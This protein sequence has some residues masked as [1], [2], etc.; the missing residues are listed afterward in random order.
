MH[1]DV[2]SISDHATHHSSRIKSA[3]EALLGRAGQ[4]SFVIFKER[5]SEKFVQ[6]AGSAQEPLLFD[7]PSI[8]LNTGEME[9]A[10]A[11]FAKLGVSPGPLHNEHVTFQL[12]LNRNVDRASEITLSVFRD[13]YCFPPSFELDVIEN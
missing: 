8:P 11:F 7:L 12:K 5:K 4:D 13:V 9:R 2:Q 6:F 1:Q 10:K 3:L